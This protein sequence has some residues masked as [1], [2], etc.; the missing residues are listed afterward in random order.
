MIERH[1]KGVARK[2]LAKNYVSYL[3]TYTFPALE[4]IQGFIG[5]T[6]LT[7]TV[8]DG[9][10]F[11]VITRWESIEAITEFAGES[12]NKAVVSERVQQMMVRYD[13]NVVHY[14]VYE[15]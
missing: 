1:W 10:E 15:A 9:I 4:K 13:S 3:S 14:N 2:D 11:L 7:R 8:E 5:S 6:I 12:L